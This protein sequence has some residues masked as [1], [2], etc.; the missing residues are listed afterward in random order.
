MSQKET[1]GD[2]EYQRTQEEQIPLLKWDLHPRG[3]FGGPSVK[4][5]Q[6]DLNLCRSFF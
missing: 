5:V 3:L 6:L 4:A 1:F 2:W